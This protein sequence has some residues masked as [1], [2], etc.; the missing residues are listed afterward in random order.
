MRLLLFCPT[1]ADEIFVI[2]VVTLEI[3]KLTGYTKT[4]VNNWCSRNHIKHFTKGNI[5][6]IPKLFLIDFF[7]SLYFRSITRKS[8]WHTKTLNEFQ[9]IIQH[10]STKLGNRS[11]RKYSGVPCKT[12]IFLL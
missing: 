6:Y 1:N 9:H 12:L 10:K 3:V 5:H 7:C 4:T 11:S 2:A 8:D